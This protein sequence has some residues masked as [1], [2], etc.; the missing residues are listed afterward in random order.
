MHNQLLYSFPFFL[1]AALIL[2][3]TL[4][5]FQR[6][7]VKGCW[8]LALAGLAATVW[9]GCEGLLYLGFDIE[10]NMLIT[11]LEYLGVAPLPPLMLLFG[12]CHFGYESWADRK[13]GLLL[14]LIAVCIVALVWTNP[15]H[16]LIFT[17]YYAIHTGPFPML[18]L[19]HGPLWWVILLYHY[20]LLVVLSIILI[21]QFASSSGYQRSQAGMILVAVAFVWLSNLIYVTGNSPVPN[22]DISPIAFVMVAGAMA[23]GFYRY[24]L[25]DILP[26]AKE[27]IFQSI[28]DVILVTDE[29]GRVLD[30]NRAAEHVLKIKAFQ[31]IGQTVAHVFNYQQFQEIFSNRDGS[32]ICLLSDGKER[33]Y[34]FRAS[35][36][37]DAKGMMVGKIIVLRDITERKNAEKE[38]LENERRLRE[39]KSILLELSKI[40]IGDNGDLNTTMGTITKTVAHNLGVE[41][42]SVW[43]F[44][45][46]HSK[47]KCIEL[48]EFGQQRH[49]AGMEFYSTDLPRYFEALEKERTVAVSDVNTDPRTNAVFD[50]YFK[51]LGVTSLLDSQ[52]RSGGN[53]VG[54]FSIKHIGTPRQWTMD[55]QTF[56]ASIADIVSLLIEESELKKIKRERKKLEAQFQ[57]VEKME[58]IGTLAG[59]VAHDL[60]NILSGLVGYPELLLMDLQEN[61]HLRKPLLTIQKS[62][63]KASA[64]VQDLL[65][66]T[67]RGVAVSEVV[68]LN[69]IISDYLESPEQEKVAYYNP[70][71]RI[72]A[73]LD[74]DLLHIIGSPVHLSKTVMNIVKNAS[75]AMPQGGKIHISTCNQYLDTSINGY[76]YIDEGDYVV[77]SVS[78]T[79][80]GISPEDKERI[81]EPF[82]TKKVMGKS[83]TGLG[84]AVVWGTVKDHNG[85]IDVQ[86]IE[87]KGTTFRLYFPI[88]RKGLSEEKSALPIE[89]YRGTGESILIVDD[90]E[91]QRELAS[92]MLQKIGYRVHIVRSGEEAI[93]YLTTNEVD[94]LLLDMIMAPGMD[95]LDTY[96]KI[97]ELHPNQKAIIASG[98]SETER[99][100]ELQRLGAGAYVKK[101]YT[102]EKIGMAVKKE[103]EK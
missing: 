18:A 88:T 1:S 85:Y 51:P 15:L 7:N 28:D 37:V 63:E 16:G 97:I 8:Y 39:Q 91:E 74:A 82:Y 77:L 27:K 13:T 95:G 93:D 57:R 20:F 23:W 24:R 94:I 40:K 101:P 65:T 49:C 2:I 83:G 4:F 46:E 11:K 86:S 80:T 33:V 48:Y 35:F 100:K 69:H 22:M 102:L 45:D 31:A 5:V 68:N 84:M 90:V 32:E 17:D 54:V 36:I 19:K 42:V 78:D 38:L 50:T 70:D 56:A 52:I 60:N 62:G 72:E 47:I 71:V 12:L 43:L 67:R 55:E 30:I 81:F 21:L 10:T 98:Y 41:R 87:G 75:E 25:L 34:D 73:D 89:N 96:K 26:V 53:A 76:D 6:V 59:G 14:F 44:N 29:R 9:A 61:S 58:V 3:V 92:S 99:V 103:L 66:L 64:I 79:G